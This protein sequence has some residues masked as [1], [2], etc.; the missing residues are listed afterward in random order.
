M[1]QKFDPEA[2]LDRIGRRLVIEFDDASQAGTPGL[3]GA[4]REHPA[5][6][7]LERLLPGAAA[8][9][10]GL[11]IDS[12]G[13]SSKQQDIVIFE[14]AWCPVFSINETP[15]ATFFPCE[16]VIATG[17]VKSGLDSKELE[18]AF[19]KIASVKR[20]RRHAPTSRGALNLPE[21]VSFRKFGG[22]IAF[23]GVK[24]EEFD[25]LRKTSDQIYGF[26][27]CGEFRLKAETIFEK[28]TELWKRYPKAES[29]NLIVSLKDGF[30]QHFDSGRNQFVLSAMDANAVAFSPDEKRSMG[31]LIGVLNSFARTARTV[32]VVHFRRYFAT[33]GAQYPL[34]AISKV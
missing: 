10:S 3:V 33:D 2:F 21:A 12:Y 24:S 1:T 34:A 15:E 32:E 5:R 30:I 9:G 4:S 19:E 22:A 23:D 11:V 18:D 16:G 6:K 27:L 7:S 20:L 28:A 29:P 17:E 26:I 31:Y 13:N 8:V 14:D 25:Q